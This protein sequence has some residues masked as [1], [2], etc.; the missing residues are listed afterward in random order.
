MRHSL[1]IKA[2]VS[3]EK[4]AINFIKRNNYC[5]LFLGKEHRWAINRI[6]NCA[7]KENKD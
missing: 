4:V 1:I 2:I 5:I 6:M 3:T 7:L